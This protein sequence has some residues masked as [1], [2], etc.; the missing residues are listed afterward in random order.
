MLWSGLRLA[1]R[2][3]GGD[4]RRRTQTREFALWG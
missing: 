1:G 3:A 4:A 2:P